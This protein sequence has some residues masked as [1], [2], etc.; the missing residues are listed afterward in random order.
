MSIINPEK[1]FI[2]ALIFYF[3]TIVLIMIFK[4]NIIYRK[5]SRSKKFNFPV[6]TTSLVVVIYFFFLMIE[7][8]HVK[9]IN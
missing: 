4:P 9:L 7:Y 2:N 3:I 8:I 6:V 1:P 5:K